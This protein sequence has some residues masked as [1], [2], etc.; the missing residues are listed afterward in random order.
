MLSIRFL[1]VG[2][3][4]QPSYKIVVVDKRRS[5][6]SGKFIEQL[7]FYNPL[8]KEKG[9][10][11]ERAQ[12]WLS[13]GAQPSDTVHNLLVKEGLIEGKKV[14]VHSTKQRKK[15]E[16]KKAPVVGEPASEAPKEEVVEK[17]KPSVKEIKEEEA[18]KKEEK[19][20]KKQEQPKEQKKPVEEKKAVEKGEDK[21]VDKSE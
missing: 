5:P 8:T 3:K 7:G 19:E 18:E 9:I 6:K 10:N 12:Y 13:Q 14:A 11:K 21:K 1:R 16:V 20:V 2:K 15:E 17:E 4:H